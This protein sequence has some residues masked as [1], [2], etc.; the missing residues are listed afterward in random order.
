[1]SIR[2]I[3][4]RTVD[5]GFYTSIGDDIDLFHRGAHDVFDSIQI[6]L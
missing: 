5:G 4:Y 6:R 2:C 3:S 1:M